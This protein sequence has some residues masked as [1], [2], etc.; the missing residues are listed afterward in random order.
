MSNDEARKTLL[1]KI[2]GHT[3]TEP[4]II[5]F[6]TG[7]RRQHWNKNC[8]ALGL[9][10]GFIEPLESTSIHMIQ[11]GITR[12]I[13]MFPHEGI[14]ACDIDEYNEQMRTETLTIRDFVVMHYH[15]TERE[16][17]AFWRYCKNMP[18]PASLEH[19]IRLFKETGK[20]FVESPYKL[21]AEPSWLQVMVGQG[22]IPERYHVVANEMTDTE[23]KK[24]LEDI[25]SYVKQTVQKMPSHHDY[26]QYYCKASAWTE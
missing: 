22:I 16:D 9:A 4:K 3:I 15:L 24:F 10:S 26:L 11:R 19:R 23:L 8:V 25:R 2:E 21:F 6:T 20:I 17:S 7:Q 1:E 12:L 5:K 18:I 14:R 13:Q